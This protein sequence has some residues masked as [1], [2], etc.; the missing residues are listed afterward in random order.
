MPTIEISKADLEKLLGKKLTNNELKERAVLF[1]K[2]EIEAIAGDYV[3]IELKDTNRPDLLS[4]EGIARELKGFYGIEL[5]LPKFKVYKSRVKVSVDPK[6]KNI[7]PKGAYAIAKRV[8]VTEHLL[9][10]MIQL[11]EKICETFGRKRREIAIGIFDYDK[12]KGNLR[13]YAADPSEEFVPLGF[14]EKLSLS[15][16]LE[17][18]PK[19]IE[20][21]HLIDS[22]SKYPLLVDSQNEVLSMP[23]IINSEYS[24][25]VTTETENLFIDVTGFNQETINIA[26]DIICAALHDRKAR[27]ESVTVDY[28]N[29][30]I[31]TPILGSQEI[32]VEH[33][34]IEN[35]FGEKVSKDSIKRFAKMKRMDCSFVKNAAVVRYPS[36]RA[37]VLHAIDI[38]ED[39][40]IA[41]DYNAIEPEPVRIPTKGYEL[42]ERAL[43][44]AVREACIGL[45]LQEVLTFT[46]TSK[47]KQQA[48][49][50]LPE[51][52]FVELEN[53]LSS[54][55]CVFR[56]SIV[57]E[58]LDFLSKNK[59]C[60]YPQKI[61]EVG[62]V[63]RP[64]L[65]E[66]TRVEEKDVLCVAITH[67]DANFNE[68][69]ACLDAICKAMDWHYEM[70]RA[71][72][73]AF[74][75]G[76]CAYIRLGSKRGIIGEISEKVLANFNLKVPV[77]V[78]EL[79]L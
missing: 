63:V 43:I 31:V 74:K 23:P 73:A 7:R 32:V 20:Y 52:R 14:N 58:L 67:K 21:R 77:A 1:V 15:E 64:K 40:L 5:G 27:I 71:E 9:E 42:A 3:K 2:G 19:G 59:H 35:I 41:R 75:K 53:P 30:K 6:L 47:E 36:Y 39:L 72:H 76:L 25:K 4:A 24:G 26:L 70:V 79:E 68:I 46:L 28:G 78:L 62:R 44:D 22:H 60:A 66:E 61:F 10:Q 34:L 11:Q 57:P 29:K 50:L 37:D 12:V 33:A 17:R 54:E 18:H 38:V 8:H 16:I 45:Q 48:K 56:Q 69:K 13:Y 49:M 55:Y 65:S 51:L